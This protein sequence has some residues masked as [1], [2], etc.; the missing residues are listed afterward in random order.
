MLIFILLF[1]GFLIGALTVIAVEA[2]GLLFL[3]KRLSRKAK[4]KEEKV[5]SQSARSLDPSSHTKK[6]GII[7][8]LNPEKVPK[9][10]S[11]DKVPK[12]NKKKKEIVEI[13]PVRIFAKLKDKSLILDPADGTLREVQLKGCIVAAVS[14]TA[15]ASRKW[16][17]RYPIKVE[18][19]TTILYEGSK[20][21]YIYLETSWEKESWCKALR[22][23][24]CADKEKLKWLS[25]LN[26]EFQTYLATLNSGYPLFM[27]PFLGSDTEHSDRTAKPDGSSKVRH[28]FQKLSK[29]M[30]KNGLDNKHEEKKVGD[31]WQSL[32]E[33]VF[34]SDVTKTA[35][36]RKTLSSSIEGKM[37]PPSRMGSASSSRSLSLSD[38]DYDEKIG[39][40]EGTL[41]WNMLISR[42][43]FD[44]K[45][46]TLIKSSIHSRIQRTLS[47]MRIPSYIGEITCTNIDLGSLPP[48]I[49]A[50]RVLPSDMK[51][52]WA[53]EID[54][55]YS[56]EFVLDVETR[57]DVCESKM[58]TESR[59]VEVPPDILEDFEYL[60][61][62]LELSENTSDSP[63]LKESNKK[64]SPASKWKSA[65]SSVAKQV[66]Q[67]PISLGVKVSSLKG[68]LQL[69]IKP[70][71]SD[72]LWFGFTSMPEIDF[73]LESHVGERKINSAR[74]VS[75]LISRFK[76]AIREVLVLPN[77]ENVCIP[78]MLAEK[79]NW[80]P[81]K[82]APFIW[83]AHHQEVADP[84]SVSTSSTIDKIVTNRDTVPQ[85][86]TKHDKGKKFEELKTP[87]L[88]RNDGDREWDRGRYEERERGIEVELSLSRS[89]SD[90]AEDCPQFK[91]MGTKAR[92]QGL[93][94]K[95]SEK[96]E[97]KKRSI[98]E[99]SR[100]MVEKIKGPE[101][102]K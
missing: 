87:L 7:W 92:M 2:F 14:A 90:G 45:R 35:P 75:F 52:V 95:M 69:H 100:H 78:W 53:L 28:Y 11:I 29:K 16:A 71:P 39:G 42:L 73:E 33:L 32:Q 3:I 43:F 19:E 51:E 57:L 83:R 99:K 18:S 62:H 67:V 81:C 79:D 23:A 26:L 93:R 50:M 88:I 97:E 77:C 102:D 5:A 80:V 58:D 63:E 6:Q 10:K 12:E 98:E 34:A 59:L 60:G 56:G 84:P 25:E 22:V 101:R 27:K 15:L 31:K 82:V 94:K 1:L 41:C 21:I 36:I 44:A 8:I 70:P 55:Q 38:V 46:N 72:Q 74:L 85:V 65:L 47:N 68:T 40:D 20:T 48:Y 13:T 89:S 37:V 54:I 76:A 86:V 91:K 30:S 66:S 17:K 96:F 4:Q 9:S 24:S 61:E 49:S 64:A